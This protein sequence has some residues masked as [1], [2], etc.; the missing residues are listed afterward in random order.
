M[1]RDTNYIKPKSTEERLAEYN[2][3]FSDIR[4]PD[5]EYN[6]ERVIYQNEAYRTGDHRFYTEYLQHTYPQHLD[7]ETKKFTRYSSQIDA[8]NREAAM[9]FV[10]ENKILLFQSDIYILDEDAILSAFTAP[11]HYVDHFDMYESWGNLINCFVLPEILFLEE[12]EVF[13]INTIIQ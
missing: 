1:K 5:F 9:H 4:N 12:R 11:S 8:M 3:A 13:L 6:Y 10:E 2:Q 7:E